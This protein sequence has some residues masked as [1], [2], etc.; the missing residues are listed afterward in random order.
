MKTD[1]INQLKNFFSQYKEIKLV[2]LFGSQTGSQAGPLSDYDFAIYL[3]ERIN[4]QRKKDIIFE[5]NSNLSSI[6]KI[7]EIDVVIIND[8]LS[9]LL[10]YNII[11]EGVLVYEKIPFRLLLEPTILSAYFDFQVFSKSYNL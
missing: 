9:P 5:L 10:K 6:L 7:N 1:T 11:K 2:Y 8:T 3:E 4:L